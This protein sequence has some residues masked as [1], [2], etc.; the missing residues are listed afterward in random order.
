MQLDS[1][2]DAEFFCASFSFCVRGLW[3]P[4][5]LS[6]CDF[7]SVFD[8]SRRQKTF[9]T[10]HLFF[11]KSHPVPSARQQK[12][13]F[14]SPKGNK[15]NPAILPVSIT[16]EATTC[17]AVIVDA[18][19]EIRHSQLSFEA[20]IVKIELLTAEM[21]GMQLLNEGTCTWQKYP[22]T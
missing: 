1:W 10:V 19:L 20:S 14:S 5:M 11:Q 16:T 18:V 17:R 3:D 7:K 2:N 15:I 21:H 22:C 12:N 8:A 13:D 6:S 9:I 4:W